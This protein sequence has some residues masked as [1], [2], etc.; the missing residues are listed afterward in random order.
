MV[1]ITKIYI[2][3]GYHQNHLAAQMHIMVAL[4]RSTNDRFQQ[5]VGL[6]S[7]SSD[8]RIKISLISLPTRIAKV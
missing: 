4:K 5:T 7:Q 2:S 6:Y 3:E 1:L 8:C